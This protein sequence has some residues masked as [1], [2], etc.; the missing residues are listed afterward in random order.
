MTLVSNSRR[1]ARLQA[2]AI[3]VDVVIGMFFLVMTTLS[4][5]SLFPVIKKG[6][7]LS[8]ER[9]KAVQI[10]NRMLEHV[11]MLGAKDVS[12]DNLVALNLIDTTSATQPYSF[13][14]VPMDEASRYSPAQTLRNAK[15]ELTY[16]DLGDGSVLIQ[17]SLTYTSDSGHA[18]T[19]KTG[20]VIG[21]FR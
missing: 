12:Y 4:L 3:L 9:S 21:G 19:V 5:M 6:E 1:R 15:G 17:V 16:S 20:T 14:Q 18:E 10:C 2:G 13:T 11:Q 7:Q 8:T